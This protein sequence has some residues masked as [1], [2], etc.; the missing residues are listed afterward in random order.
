MIRI[1][2]LSIYMYFFFIGCSNTYQQSQSQSNRLLLDWPKMI[3]KSIRNSKLTTGRLIIHSFSI[4]FRVKVYQKVILCCD[5]DF[6]H[7]KYVPK[8]SYNCLPPTF[9]LHISNYFTTLASI[10]SRMDGKQLPFTHRG[11]FPCLDWHFNLL[12]SRSY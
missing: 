8:V 9:K 6:S 2:C 12:P 7:M 4:D 3:D 11:T 10:Y 5:L 1:I